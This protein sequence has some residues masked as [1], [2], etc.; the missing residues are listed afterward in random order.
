[1]L[2]Q[3]KKSTSEE[4]AGEGESEKGQSSGAAACVDEEAANEELETTLENNLN[5]AVEA[6]KDEIDFDLSSP[7]S[8][9]LDESDELDLINEMMIQPP[10]THFQHPRQP[11]NQNYAHCVNSY[12]QNGYQVRTLN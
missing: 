4:E 5:I 2:I 9:L 8:N 6:T 1:M 7:L 3:N 10:T 11:P 12:R